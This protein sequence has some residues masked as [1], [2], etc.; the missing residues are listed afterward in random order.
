MACEELATNSKMVDYFPSYE[1]IT[2]PFNTH[3]YY[4]A[5]RRSVQEQGVDYVMRVFETYTNKQLA[6]IK[7]L[8]REIVVMSQTEI[9][10]A[11]KTNYLK[12]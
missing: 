1:I 5:N 4:D 11:M 12:P 3:H 7:V 10:F 9:W 6:L 8:V 2:E